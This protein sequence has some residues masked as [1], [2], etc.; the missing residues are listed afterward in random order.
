MK[1]FANITK[2]AAF[3]TALLLAGTAFSSASFARTSDHGGYRD[4]DRG[5]VLVNRDS[6]IDSIY[7]APFYGNG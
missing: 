3:L 6:G 1:T 7:E 5:G 2:G 4:T